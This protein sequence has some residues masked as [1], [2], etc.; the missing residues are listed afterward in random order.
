MVAPNL[1]KKK[2]RH[3]CIE[4]DVSWH[5]SFHHCYD[6]SC[7]CRNQEARDQQEDEFPRTRNSTTKHLLVASSIC[8]SRN[9][10]HFHSCWDARVLLQLSTPVRIRTMGFTLYTSVF[11]L[12]SFLSE[13]ASMISVIEA[14]TGSEGRKSCFSDDMRE[15]GLNKYYWL[16]A[17]ASA[18]SLL[19]YAIFCK[20]YTTRSE[21]ENVNRK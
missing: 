7:S 9:F 8:S 18:L 11:G 10:R 2:K 16:L 19:F 1:K 3:Y 12:G 14:F 17:L 6:H 5:V 4:V 21:L 13:S 20:F 15:D